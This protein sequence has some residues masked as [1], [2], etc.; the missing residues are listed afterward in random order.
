[1]RG[2]ACELRC[3]SAPSPLLA[4]MWLPPT[5]LLGTF[6][7]QDSEGGT[8]HVAGRLG[9]KTDTFWPPVFPW[10]TERGLGAA[11]PGGLIGR[12]CVGGSHGEP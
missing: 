6:Y 7:R 12:P 3:I 9:D 5:I 1:M 8:M 10:R 4:V 11:M 2:D